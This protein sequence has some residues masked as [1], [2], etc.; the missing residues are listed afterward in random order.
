V[1]NFCGHSTSALVICWGNDVYGLDLSDMSQ[2][3]Q[4]S[5]TVGMSLGSDEI[6]LREIDSCVIQWS[7]KCCQALSEGL[8][9]DYRLQKIQVIFLI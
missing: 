3:G 7:K 9:D 6:L 8:I 4:R 2:K 1:V 5:L